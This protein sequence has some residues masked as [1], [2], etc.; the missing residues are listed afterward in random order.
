MER[1][2]T[3]NGIAISPYELVLPQAHTKNFNNHHSHFTR[4]KFER[5]AVTTALRNLERHQY[6]M[7]VDVH[8]AL[9]DMYAPPEFP[10]EQQAAREV[11]DAYEHGERFK[12]YNRR[13]HWYDFKEIPPELANEFVAKYSLVRIFDM[14]A[15]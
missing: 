12:I 11:I 8:E 7:P 14:A 15:D 13:C 10:S 2:P 9:H 6:E 5:H 1:Y 4:K 3:R